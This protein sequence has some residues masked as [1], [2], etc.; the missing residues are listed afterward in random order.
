MEITAKTKTLNVFRNFFK[1]PILE[2]TLRSI[3]SNKMLDSFFVKLIPNNYQYAPNTNR[4]IIRNGI[5]FKV[6]LFDYIGWSLYFGLKD[7]GRPK[8][9]DLI[10][11][12]HTV[13]DVGTNIGETLMNFAKLT[14]PEGEVHGF[15]P[16]PLNYQ[17]C[18]E[19]LELNNFNNIIPNNLG[20]GA[21][22]GEY[23]IKID[24]PSNRGGNKISAEYIENNTE[25]IQ[26]ITLDQYV[27]EKKIKKID[28]IKIDVE[29][30]ELQVLKGSEQLIQRFKP[31]FFIELDDSNLKEQG[32]SAKALIHYLTQ[33]NYFIT[34]AETG[35]VVTTATNFSNCH[36]D[37]ICRPI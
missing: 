16:D 31:L 7:S 8:L 6:D 21:K 17:R 25:I 27:Q 28:L 24:T 13:I 11:K 18:C 2:K 1:I 12:N 32:D 14:Q 36:Y 29:G 4:L 10:G 35:E 3:T 30:Y 34:N 37:I 26:I 19:N 15:E 23:F 9:Y 22:A 33:F 20:L 5:K